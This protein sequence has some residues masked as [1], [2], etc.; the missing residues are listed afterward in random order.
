MANYPE[1]QARAQ[2]ELDTV[3]GPDRL[4]EFSDR[5]DLPYVNAIISELLRWQPVT[6]LGTLSP[7]VRFTEMTMYFLPTG[8]PHA[9]TADDEYNGYFIPKNSIVMGNVWC[10]TFLNLR[11]SWSRWPDLHL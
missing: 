9:T 7:S 6:P 2:A 8:L 5:P 10:A 1:V 4:A 11:F 3:I